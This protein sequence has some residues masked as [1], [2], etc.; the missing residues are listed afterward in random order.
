MVT[1]ALVVPT[2][3]QLVACE[4]LL[5]LAELELGVAEIPGI[6][7]H[8]RIQEYQRTTTRSPLYI[9][10]E[11]AWCSSF[12]NWVV[13]QAANGRPELR[14]TG[15]ASARSWLRWGDAIEA[16]VP[17]CVVVFSRPPL[18]GS[19]HVALFDELG[20]D[21]RSIRVLGGNQNNRVCVAPY[22]LRRVLGYR[23]PSLA[24]LEPQLTS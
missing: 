9:R 22:P 11:V 2:G 23:V 16:P 7:N 19:G 3:A 1:P 17:G 20:D 4:G 21:G 12:V 18:P 5:R 15:S 6:R 14:G 8:P 10:D 24:M 13:L